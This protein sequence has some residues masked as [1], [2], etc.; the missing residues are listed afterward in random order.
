MRR[1]ASDSKTT[2]TAVDVLF[3][4]DAV[5][6][7]DGWQIVG[8]PLSSINKIMATGPTPGIFNGF[9]GAESGMVPVSA[10]APST[11]LQE[12]ELQRAVE[13]KDRPPLLPSPTTA[14]KG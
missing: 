1:H 13:G 10:V 6:A 8:T 5:E 3:G 12:I 2:A 4:D 14:T 9:C 7:R 11:L